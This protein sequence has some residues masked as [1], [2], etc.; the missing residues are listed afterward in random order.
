MPQWL[1]D[2]HSKLNATRVD[3]VA[4]PRTTEVVRAALAYARDRRLPLIAAG[5]RHAM[6]GQQMAQDGIVLDTRGLD[7]VLGLDRERGLVRVEAGIQWP[8]LIGA[9]ATLQA[10]GET[11]WMIRQKQTGADRFTIGGS[12][13][14]NIHG[15]G[16]ALAPFAGDVEAC[17]LLRPDGRIETLSRTENPALFRL[18]VG[19]YGLFGIVLTVTLRLA[20][21]TKLERVVEL[22]TVDDL[23]DLLAQRIA[24]GFLYGDFQFSCDESSDDFLCRGVFSCYRPVADA[25]PIPAGQRQLGAQEWQHLIHL[26]HVAK[27]EA[28]AQYSRY[29]LGTHGQLYWSDLHQLSYY[30][31]D[32]HPE[33]D[34]RCGCTTPASEMIGELYVPRRELAGFLGDARRDFRCHGTNLIYGTV[35]AIERDVDTF[36]PWARQAYACVVFNLHTE[37]TPAGVRETRDAYVRLIDRA[38]ERGGSYYLTYHRWAR[39]D[40]VLACYPEFPD[41]VAAKEQHDPDGV[42]TSDW[43]R[44]V[45]EE[46]VHAR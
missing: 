30:L 4:T 39:R 3:R 6:G 20:R 15:R 17:E 46:V 45:C 42:L 12:L 33:L 24:E 9:L 44:A 22:R 21:R 29:Y 13:S 43:Y 23:P 27:G 8:A 31:D 16:L 35:R 11:C 32:Y 2:V 26:A 19:G 40:Q 1:N 7:R 37:H 5:G 41:F 38:I 18:V 14:A 28:F 34:R 36:L 25:T 10:D